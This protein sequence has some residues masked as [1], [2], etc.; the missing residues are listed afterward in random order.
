M[1]SRFPEMSDLA[2]IFAADFKQREP[3]RMT[4]KRVQS[5]GN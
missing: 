2:V 3:W 4:D 5:L 1:F